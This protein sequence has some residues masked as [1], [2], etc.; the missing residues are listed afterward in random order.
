MPIL[1]VNTNVNSQKVPANFKTNATNVVAK[2]LGKPE[3]YIA[4]H[5]NAEQ[6]ISFGNTD[7]PAALCS[8]LSI[9]ALSTTSNK[10]HSKAITQFLTEALGIKPDRIYISFEDCNKANVGFNSTTF[11]DLI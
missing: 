1:T 3:S 8:L 10:K 4:I 11:D 6:D 2:T 5:V 7:E 9:G